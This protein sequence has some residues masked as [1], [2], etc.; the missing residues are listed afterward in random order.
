MQTKLVF[1]KNNFKSCEM[2]TNNNIKQK[3]FSFSFLSFLFNFGF[4]I[5]IYFISIKFEQKKNLFI[6]NLIKI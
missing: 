1:K 6:K 4:V 2:K 5:K 3:M